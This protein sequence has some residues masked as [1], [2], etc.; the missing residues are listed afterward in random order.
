[1]RRSA[2]VVFVRALALSLALALCSCAGGQRSGPG[3]GAAAG[4]TVQFERGPGL[5]L[6]G[7]RLAGLR[8]AVA[9]EIRYL[10]ARP[11]QHPLSAELA[12]LEPGTRELVVEAELASGP[13]GA[14]V[15]LRLRQA[16]TVQVPRSGP[17]VVT[18]FV[19]RGVKGPTLALR[20][21]GAR[22][23]PSRAP[24]LPTC[25]ALNP[26]LRSCDAAADSPARALC[27]ISAVR[28]LA[29]Q[30]LNPGWMG[31]ANHQG[32]RLRTARQ[33]HG[34]AAAGGDAKAKEALF[35][36]SAQLEAQAR[37]CVKQYFLCD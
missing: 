22:P 13:K 30:K 28:A 23:G 20:G 27:V 32:N 33:L 7:L 6:M 18:I 14:P 24:A 1:M 12:L 5:R 2:Q 26:D 34:H 25:A 11:G 9:Y 36:R 4:A 35:A 15:T 16:W 10:N 29:K 8:V 31:C 17:S 19:R 3:S 21:R 37:T